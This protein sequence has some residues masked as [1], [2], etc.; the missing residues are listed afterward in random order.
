MKQFIITEGDFKCCDLEIYIH[1]K[2]SEDC[3]RQFSH[4]IN[5]SRRTYVEAPA[6]ISILQLPVHQSALVPNR[7]RVLFV[8]K[9]LQLCKE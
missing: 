4:P 3:V 8:H 7:K 9:D 5:I 1:F 2:E 6:L